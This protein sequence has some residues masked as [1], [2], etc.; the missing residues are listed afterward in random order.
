M[1]GSVG[2]EL[3][4]ATRRLGEMVA[5]QGTG[6]VQECLRKGP[7][8]NWDGFVCALSDLEKGIR[9]TAARIQTVAS[10]GLGKEGEQELVVESS[11]VVRS[12]TD[13]LQQTRAQ[14]HIHEYPSGLSFW[15]KAII[16]VKG[17][18]GFF[19]GARYIEIETAPVD[20]RRVSSDVHAAVAREFAKVLPPGFQKDH[21][22]E[23]TLATKKIERPKESAVVE[24]TDRG[25]IR[26]IVEGQVVEAPTWEE[27]GK[28][29]D[30]MRA[31]LEATHSRRAL[32]LKELETKVLSSL[33][34]ELPD[35]SWYIRK[36]GDVYVFCQQGQPQKEVKITDTTTAK[37]INELFGVNVSDDSFVLTMLWAAEKRK[38]DLR[39][40]EDEASYAKNGQLLSSWLTPHQAAAT[41]G[42]V[43][44]GEL[45]GEKR[46]T[47]VR[48]GIGSE[49]R[50]A[51]LDID[52]TNRVFKLTIDGGEYRAST[53]D[54]LQKQLRGVVLHEE[55]IRH[56]TYVVP[57]AEKNL[58]DAKKALS[59]FQQVTG[60]FSESTQEAMEHEM[61]S[62]PTLQGLAQA[63]VMACRPWEGPRGQYFLTIVQADGVR[64]VPLDLV[65]RPGKV[66]LRREID[67]GGDIVLWPIAAS[68]T[69]KEALKNGFLAHDL[70]FPMEYTEIRQQV[71]PARDEIL[72]L[73]GQ[74]MQISEFS[75]LVHF[76]GENARNGFLIHDIQDRSVTIRW[77][78]GKEEKDVVVDLMYNPGAF[79]VMGKPPYPSLEALVQGEIGVSEPALLPHEALLPMAASLQEFVRKEILENPVYSQKDL[80]KQSLEMMRRMEIPQVWWIAQKDA[81]KGEG[82]LKGA[83][84][85]VKGLVTGE[86]GQIQEEAENRFC[87]TICMP[88]GGVEE[89]PLYFVFEG[90]RWKISEG[91][92]GDTFDTL[93]GLIQ[94]KAQ[95]LGVDPHYRYMNVQ[96]RF[97]RHLAIEKQIESSGVGAGKIV[98][99]SVAGIFTDV[100]LNK[101]YRGEIADPEPVLKAL[102]RDAVA[103]NHP[104]ACIFK[105]KDTNTYRLAVCN[106][107]G[108]WKALD[109][110]IDSKAIPGQFGV[111]GGAKFASFA[112]F[113]EE[114]LKDVWSLTDAE[115]IVAKRA[116]RAEEGEPVSGPFPEEPA[117][118]QE[119]RQA[120][121][122]T[123]PEWLDLKGSWVT[124]G[125]GKRLDRDIRKLMKN[126][127]AVHSLVK[128]YAA[129]SLN[130][131]E[132]A[133]HAWVKALGGAS[134]KLGVQD[135]EELE[136]MTREI[137]LIE[138]FWL[139]EV[140]VNPK[141]ISRR[142]RERAMH[143]LEH[144]L[145]ANI[146]PEEEQQLLDYLAANSLRYGHTQTREDAVAFL[147]GR[148]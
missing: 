119:A 148:G 35:S 82:L 132:R 26:G 44:L 22:V 108:Q 78:D 111:Q 24:V 13:L 27:L 63:G 73:I 123:R 45:P 101:Y 51:L 143:A 102:A 97:L 23:I 74:P 41:Y 107:E 116:G 53:F 65:S 106:K 58:A 5:P 114:V 110:E 139:F 46:R 62:S 57:I 40:I 29:I 118:Q 59:E 67:K 92:V 31:G 18:F 80:S 122:P 11:H 47:G 38:L 16:C 48:I 72:K 15:Q 126:V 49:M 32:L 36:K 95:E 43:T 17:F 19:T 128:C 70:L 52:D 91:T 87:I 144:C 75:S 140:S 56:I 71:G 4:D 30:E 141:I 146:K 6:S 33:P 86:R 117:P 66:I 55:P 127:E 130:T 60:D 84:R 77:W 137:P 133:F 115:G 90:G 131:D 8:G 54:D 61:G 124:V 135:L 25:E 39:L 129:G 125:K 109:L 81:K 37:N 138:R 12:A 99:R 121:P 2:G 89:I 94:A 34:S 145:K 10:E 14:F 21:K 113:K 1:S 9:D 142:R 7:A 93:D 42:F 20:V 64:T 88:D 3:R 147:R 120:A 28:R 98:L 105:L 85:W 79:T 136:R 83:G 104:L 96:E 134:E 68:H 103:L 69:V 76:L 50:T 112:A 100:F